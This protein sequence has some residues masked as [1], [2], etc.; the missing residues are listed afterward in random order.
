M[1]AAESN[2]MTVDGLTQLIP[3]SLTLQQQQQQE[4]AVSGTGPASMPWAI[5]QGLMHASYP[6]PS[7]EVRQQSKFCLIT[8]N[9]NEIL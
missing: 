5:R 7:I 2:A 8:Q 4:Y 6:P 1:I 9:N 3:H